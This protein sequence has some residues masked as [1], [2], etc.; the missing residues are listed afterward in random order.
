MSGWSITPFGVSRYV[1]PETIRLK[2]Y[3]LGLHLLLAA[4]GIETG[5]TAKKVVWTRD[6]VRLYRYQPPA[7]SISGGASCRTPRWKR[8][9]P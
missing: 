2:K 1:N 3:L 5:Q 4:T 7:S 6:K 8:C 9:S